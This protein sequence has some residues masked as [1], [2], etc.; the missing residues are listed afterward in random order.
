MVLCAQ[1]VSYLSTHLI[2]DLSVFPFRQVSGTLICA[3]C[4][5]AGWLLL[6]YNLV[7]THPYPEAFLTV[8]KCQS[9]IKTS[10]TTQDKGGN[11]RPFSGT[12]YHTHILSCSSVGKRPWSVTTWWMMGREQKRCVSPGGVHS[13]AR[14][15]PRRLNS[16]PSLLFLCIIPERSTHKGHTV[17]NGFTLHLSVTHSSAEASRAVALMSCLGGHWKSRREPFRRH[18][19]VKGKL[20][21]KWWTWRGRMRFSRKGVSFAVVHLAKVHSTGRWKPLNNHHLQIHRDLS[22]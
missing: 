21:Q 12:L 16:L 4:T 1:G 22:T 2:N 8:P 14:R 3:K 11:T 19:A 9:A 13:T 15:Y 10:R 5:E 17:N 7:G 18:T 6:S 20:Y